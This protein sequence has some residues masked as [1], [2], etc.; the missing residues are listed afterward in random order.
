M[1]N[2]LPPHP[3]AEE[4][5]TFDVTAPNRATATS[6]VTE[7]NLRLRSQDL[8]LFGKLFGSREHAPVN[9]AGALIL[10]GLVVMIVGPILPTASGFSVADFEKAL[11]ALILASLTFLG[12]YLGG[13]NIGK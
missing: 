1:S 6:P 9:I 4:N 10:L 13:G 2:S 5:T 7:T 12:G 8:G 11:A 3:R